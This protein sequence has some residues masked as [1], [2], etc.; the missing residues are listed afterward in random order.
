MC[1]GY[2]T[3]SRGVIT[4]PNYPQSYEN[5]QDCFW[6]LRTRPGRTF[7]FSFD[8]LNVTSSDSNVCNEDY[9]ILRNGENSATSPL[10]L[11]HPG[12][13]SGEQNGR[14]CGTEPP[15]RRN[16]SSN[17][18]SIAFH[19]DGNNQ[20]GNGFR[21]HFEETPSG[22]GGH[23]RIDESEPEFDFS[24]PNYPNVPP[25]HSECIWT[26]VAPSDRRIRIDFLENFDVRP[27]RGCTV[28]GIEMRDGGTEF[29]DL[30][31]VFCNSKPSSQR[32]SSNVIRVRYFTNSDHPN[33]GFKAKATIGKFPPLYLD[34]K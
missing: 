21:M 28:A 15:E 7:T 26:I 24:S 3:S 34:A 8:H 32:G 18:M 1:G 31:G 13:G 6:V 14:L 33:P 23:V 2:L 22:C 10:I 17:V 27:T 29:S 11:M 25:P 5:S 19:S 12:Q 9:L 4:S 16:S 20:Q 30:I